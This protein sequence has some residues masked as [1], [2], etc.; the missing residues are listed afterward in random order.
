MRRPVRAA[1]EEVVGAKVWG[2]STG[3]GGRVVGE[4]FTG[5]LTW[6]ARL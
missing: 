6:R 5:S 3:V 2:V 1:R 4:I